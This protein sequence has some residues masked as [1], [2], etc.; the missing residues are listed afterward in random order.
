MPLQEE[1]S[2]KPGVFTKAFFFSFAVAMAF[3]SP[4]ALAQTAPE[5]P[6]PVALEKCMINEIGDAI[7]YCDL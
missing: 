7:C 6:C 2:M 5:P 1:E 4:L 3:F